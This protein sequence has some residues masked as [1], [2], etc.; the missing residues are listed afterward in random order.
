MQTAN[1]PVSSPSSVP[2]RARTSISSRRNR[3]R[4]TLLILFVVLVV[5]VLA[6]IAL[7]AVRI[8]TPQLFGILAQKIGWNLDVNFSTQQANVLWEI[9]LP[10]VLFA[11]LFGAALAVAGAAIQGLF[12]NPLADPGLIGVSSGAAFTTVIFIVAAGSMPLWWR[13]LPLMPL[14]G[15]AGGLLATC[16]VYAFGR[17]NW[18]SSVAAMLLAGIAINAFAMACTGLVTFLSNDAQLRSITFW[19]LGS[20]GAATWPGVYI[21]APLI[22]LSILFMATQSRALNALLLGET[23]AHHLGY[24]VILTRRVVIVLS[25]ILVGTAVAASGIISFV[26]LVVPHLLRLLVGADHRFLL[27]GSA[28]LGALLLSLADLLCRMVVAPVE[29]PIGVVTAII[30]APFFLWLLHR[31]RKRVVL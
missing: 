13:A 17:S 18:R 15:F 25:A 14:A 24:S 31:Q 6:S 1:L 10:R 11:I 7:G 30:G 23:E 8:S 26:G 16:V 22:L 19:M 29:I 5:V 3:A 20:L 4:L 28:L 9:R 21:A 27:P 12:R 2:L